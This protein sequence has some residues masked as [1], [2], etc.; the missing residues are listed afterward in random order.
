MDMIW[1]NGTYT[2]VH[3]TY[4]YVLGH[5]C[6]YIHVLVQPVPKPIE[7]VALSAKWNVH[8]WNRLRK[9]SS[10]LYTR[11]LKTPRLQRSN[12]R[13]FKF[14]LKLAWRPFAIGAIFKKN[15]SHRKM[16]AGMP[17]AARLPAYLVNS[18][19]SVN[20]LSL[21]APL[22]SDNSHFSKWLFTQSPRSVTENLSRS[23][24]RASW[25]RSIWCS[26]TLGSVSGHH[27]LS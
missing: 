25:R 16:C 9:C 3:G 22:G 24:R 5:S 8:I 26:R 15:Q 1:Q 4:L 17:R 10:R 6:T 23:W 12:F 2:S 20:L 19:N 7:N 14:Q 18:V 13:R 11:T 27:P 21:F